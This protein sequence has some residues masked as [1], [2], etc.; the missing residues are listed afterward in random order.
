MVKETEAPRMPPS[1]LAWMANWMAV[2]L[3]GVDNRGKI[4]LS[5][6]VWGGGDKGQEF[7]LDIP[8]GGAVGTSSRQL[9][10]CGWSSEQVWAHVLSHRHQQHSY[11]PHSQSSATI[12]AFCPPWPPPPTCIWWA[13][14]SFSVP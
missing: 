14:V 3:T 4:W 6:G 1:L 10:V 5:N 2:A 9:A 11:P 7:S 13:N 12:A 8:D